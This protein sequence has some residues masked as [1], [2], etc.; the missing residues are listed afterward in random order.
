[1]VGLRFSALGNIISGGGICLRRKV[2]AAVRRAA[3]RFG[4]M[5]RLPIRTQTSSRGD[6]IAFDTSPTDAAG[7]RNSISGY[8]LIY[9]TAAA[10]PSNTC[11]LPDLSYNSWI[12]TGSAMSSLPSGDSPEHFICCR[13]PPHGRSR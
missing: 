5:K 10:T 8:Y 2:V 1:M 4:P 9:I 7:M 6:L 13:L 12:P 11:R 3:A